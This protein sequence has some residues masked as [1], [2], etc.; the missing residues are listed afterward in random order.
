MS[1]PGNARKKLHIRWGKYARWPESRR[2]RQKI[3]WLWPSFYLNTHISFCRED[4]FSKE[5]GLCFTAWR[6]HGKRLS[7]SR[8]W[9]N[10]PTSIGFSAWSNSIS[11]VLLTST[12][13]VSTRRLETSRSLSTS[14]QW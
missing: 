4:P 1:W 10:G 14:R 9:L 6:L 8:K 2:K 7:R 11:A 5:R 12:G 13:E 3:D